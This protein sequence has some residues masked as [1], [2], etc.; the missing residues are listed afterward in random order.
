MTTLSKEMLK[1]TL[2][3]EGRNTFM[4][5]DMKSLIHKMVS[6]GKKVKEIAAVI[7]GDS[8]FT[9]KNPKQTYNRVF[10]YLSRQLKNLSK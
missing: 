4:T 1:Q 3:T 9:I 5:E 10:N 7:N 6:E 8:R 2:T